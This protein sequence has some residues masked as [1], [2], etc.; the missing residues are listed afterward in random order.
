MLAVT[1]AEFQE[2]VR[3]TNKLVDKREQWLQVALFGLFGEAGGVLSALKKEERDPGSLED[4]FALIA[5]ELGDTLWYWGALCGYAGLPLETIAQRVCTEALREAPGQAG[6]E[7]PLS[8]QH[9]ESAVRL[10]ELRSPCTLAASLLTLGKTVGAVFQESA[11]LAESVDASRLPLVHLEELL[12]DILKAIGSVA[13]NVQHCLNDIAASNIE[14]TL[15]RWP[16]ERIYRGLFDEGEYAYEQLPRLIEFEFREIGTTSRPQVLLRSSD[17]NIGDRLTDNSADPD[18]YRFHDVF[19]MA[20]AVHLGW[21]P[22]MRGLLKVKRK[23]DPR[24]DENED[25]ARA[26][27]IEE[28][29][30]TWIFNYAARRGYFEKNKN[31]DFSILKTVREMVRG[32]EVETCPFWQW[33]HAI[34]DGY[35]VFNLLRAH[36]GGVVT[37]NLEGRTLEFKE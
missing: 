24:I 36:K 18:Y 4:L 19:H 5:E 34:L 30:T 31:L 10:A 22:V 25:G 28:G 3:K 37:L 15:G 26:M 2:H 11:L 14:K 23:R 12:T 17:L 32:Y 27:L 8:F 1:L 35:R 20:Y 6:Y 16:Q 9:V 29:I 21:S 33:E 13:L 7:R